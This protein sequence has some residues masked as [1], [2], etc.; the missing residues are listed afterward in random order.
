MTVTK[1]KRQYRGDSAEARRL[2]RRTKLLDAAKR[3]FG[4]R[5][6]HSTTV[7]AIC[8]EA[9]LT[10]R[11]FYESFPGNEALFIAMHKRT[12]D[13]IISTLSEAL[14][15]SRNPLR[16][17]IEAYFQDIMNDPVSAK[18]FAVDA[19]FISRSAS[20]VCA[21]W[22][23]SFGQILVRATGGSLSDTS[24]ILRSGI[25]RALLGLGVDWMDGGFA[26]PRDEIVEAGLRIAQ[27]LEQQR[28]SI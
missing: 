27:I 26:D 8:E 25:V 28:S 6:F 13:R 24:P 11:Y 15:G 5:G 20:E 9:G 12:S 17:V 21:S 18:L 10:E 1:V 14:D 16:A 23:T 4:Q 2:E 7:K 22:R 3:L 19:G